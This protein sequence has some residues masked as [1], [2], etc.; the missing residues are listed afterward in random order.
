M[1]KSGLFGKPDK[2]IRTRIWTPEQSGLARF[3][4][5]YF[6]ETNLTVIEYLRIAVGACNRFKKHGTT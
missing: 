3:H 2:I 6:F 5:I 1:S 4:C